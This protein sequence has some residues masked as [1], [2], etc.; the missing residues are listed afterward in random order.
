MSGIPITR[1]LLKCGKKIDIVGKKTLFFSANSLYA[2]N[3]G[4]GGAM[5]YF[6]EVHHAT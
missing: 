5:N 6:Q 4:K 1:V 3:I 2:G